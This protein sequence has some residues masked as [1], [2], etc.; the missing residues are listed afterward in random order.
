[1]PNA[2]VIAPDVCSRSEPIRSTF[3]SLNESPPSGHFGAEVEMRTF[4]LLVSA[5]GLLGLGG[6]T[7]VWGNGHPVTDDRSLPFFDAVEGDTSLDIRVVEGETPSVTITTDG[8]IIGDITTE[9]VAGTLR[10]RQTVDVQPQTPSLV[11]IVMPSL[12]SVDHDGAG[13]M[14]VEGFFSPSLHLGS[15]G[16]GHFTGT[17]RANALDVSATGSG[18]TTLAGD[19][20]ALTLVQDGSGSVDASGTTRLTDSGS[21]SID[22]ELDDGTAELAVEASGSIHWRGNASVTSQTITGSGSIIHE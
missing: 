10:V 20:D 5:V 2:V 19:T 6:C 15:H 8:N 16:S 9:V 11:T 21:G 4:A 18:G 7:G 13:A 14:T 22:A 12:R 17:V 3:L 1:M